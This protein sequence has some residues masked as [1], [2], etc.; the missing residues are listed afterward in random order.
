M[1]F[2]DYY[3][4]SPCDTKFYETCMEAKFL[5]KG[6]KG[7]WSGR[8]RGRGY[9]H[10]IN[11]NADNYMSTRAT[12]VNGKVLVVIMGTLKHAG[13]TF[14][15]V[16]YGDDLKKTFYCTKL[17]KYVTRQTKQNIIRLIDQAIA[18]VDQWV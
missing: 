8:L 15:S 12:K 9:R 6:W 14:L 5:A 7:M 10:T 1:P 2:S 16:S 4:N 17:T 18:Q 3:L 13:K 11:K